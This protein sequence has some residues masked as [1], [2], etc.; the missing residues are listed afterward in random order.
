M[1]KLEIG[2]GDVFD[3]FKWRNFRWPP[4]FTTHI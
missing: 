4:M 3:G 2:L 1:G